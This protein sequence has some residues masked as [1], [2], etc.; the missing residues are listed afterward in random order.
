[1]KKKAYLFA[2]VL[3]LLLP[4]L[5]TPVFAETPDV[6]AR[7]EARA[8]ALADLA[9][10]RETGV[11]FGIMEEGVTKEEA[12]ALFA[13][14][15]EAVFTE[16]TSDSHLW[17]TLTVPEDRIL[18]ALTELSL[19]GLVQDICPNYIIY[20]DELGLLG[21]VDRDGRLTALDYLLLKRAVIGTYVL[22]GWATFLADADQN[23]EL[24]AVDYMLVKRCVLG[25]YELDWVL[26]P[27][28]ENKTWCVNQYTSFSDEE[29]YALIDRELAED[30]GETTTLTVAFSQIKEESE[31]AALLEEL[32]FS[33]DLS[34]ASVY[35]QVWHVPN[36]FLAVAI[37]LPAEQLRE[38]MFTL[39]RC[40]A[41][42]ECALGNLYIS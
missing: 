28:P 30:G 16:W 26:L 21:D 2:L 38:A 17:F 10:V 5:A 42:F 31:G 18:D 35:A 33:G 8:E 34:D 6:A 11:L 19:H 37:D 3:S 14:Y 15:G 20:L 27:L 4:L 23:G 29:L 12:E 40:E 24:N 36:K 22:E 9:E 32:G 39:R 25:T 1:M 41:I 7:R 13:G